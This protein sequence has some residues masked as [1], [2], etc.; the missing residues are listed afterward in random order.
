[1]PPVTV[2][3]VSLEKVTVVKGKKHTKEEVIVVQFS[4][5]LNPATAQNLGDYALA[6]VPKGRKKSKGDVLTRAVYNASTTTVTLT[7]RKQPVVLQP[8]LRLSITAAGLLD[9]SG[10][11][12]DGNG[13]GQPGGNYVGI[14]TKIGASAVVADQPAHPAVLAP[15]AVDAL[16]AS[17]FHSGTWP[18]LR[19]SPVGRHPG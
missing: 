12:I 6:T 15:G 17:G 13:D 19:I 11:E 14:L 10:H 4:G 5:E 16:L 8:P 2:K 1:V 7:P 18:A 9:T 3:D